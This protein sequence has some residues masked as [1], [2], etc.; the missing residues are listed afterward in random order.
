MTNLETRCALT[1]YG[2]EFTCYAVECLNDW[3]SVAVEYFIEEQGTEEC[4]KVD[5]T[6]VR[7][8]IEERIAI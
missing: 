3:L 5:W 7:A 6:F 2:E 4:A 1:A 8:Q